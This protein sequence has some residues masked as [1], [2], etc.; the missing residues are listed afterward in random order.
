M[1]CDACRARSPQSH[2]TMS[3]RY[4]GS[5]RATPI[6]D[7]IV[8][9]NEVSIDTPVRSD[10]N[11]PQALLESRPR[12]KRMTRLPPFEGLSI[13]IPRPK[14]SNG[15]PPTR[16]GTNQDLEGK[17]SPGRFQGKLL[18]IRS[19]TPSPELPDSPKLHHIHGL[20]KA[21]DY[22]YVHKR[23]VV[24]HLAAIRA[25]A[26]SPVRDAQIEAERASSAP[27][28]SRAPDWSDT[29]FYPSGRSPVP[30]RPPRASTPE[31]HQTLGQNTHL[32]STNSPAC[33]SRNT[34]QQ[35]P[36]RLS[37]GVPFWP[38]LSPNATLQSIE[39]SGTAT[40]RPG[41]TGAA[42][43]ELERS[44][45]YTLR[46]PRSRHTS[47]PLRHEITG[48]SSSSDESKFSTG[49]MPPTP[50]EMGGSRLELRGGYGPARMRGGGGDESLGVASFMKGYG[51]KC[52]RACT[53][54]GY[55][56]LTRSGGT[57]PLRIVIPERME[58]ARDKTRRIP[59]PTRLYPRSFRVGIDDYESNNFYPDPASPKRSLSPLDP[60]HESLL[61]CNQNLPNLRGGGG[62]DPTDEARVP[63]TLYFLAGGRGRPI[64]VASWNQQRPKKRMCGLFGMALYGHKAGT[65][66]K[67][68]E[69]G[70]DGTMPEK[71]VLTGTKNVSFTLPSDSS[72]SSSSF[73]TSSNGAKG[74]EQVALQVQS[75]L[76]AVVLNAAESASGLRAPD[77]KIPVVGDA[78]TSAALG[79]PPEAILSNDSPVEDDP[80]PGL[81]AANGDAQ[82]N[83]TQAP[84]DPT[85]KPSAAHREN[86]TDNGI[87]SRSPN[88][89]NNSENAIPSSDTPH[90][91]DEAGSTSTCEPIHDNT[92]P[93]PEESQDYEPSKDTHASNGTAQT[94]NDPS[95][96]F[97]AENLAG[98]LDA[99]AITTTPSADGHHNGDDE[100]TTPAGDAILQNE[101][102]PDTIAKPTGTCN[103]AEDDTTQGNTP[104]GNT[105]TDT[106]AAS[107]GDARNN[108]AK[109]ANAPLEPKIVPGY[110]R[111][112]KKRGTTQT[113]KEGAN[114]PDPAEKN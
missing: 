48:S 93:A 81:Q 58:G 84:A 34:R 53:T 113:G 49:T 68:E 41:P 105:D 82:A 112:R 21:K 32:Q 51:E 25:G 11:V 45:V 22:P 12:P 20:P 7:A 83:S 29:V 18:P 24:E 40:V 86:T 107:A 57:S 74:D 38:A 26:P 111:G 2:L 42:E 63:A 59:L 67:N 91:G 56:R 103:T 85:P 43:T 61:A 92:T 78:P 94:E 71:S 46:S 65:P 76:S 8:E 13:S 54:C 87:N 47:S 36:L 70:T 88:K 39:A 35:P 80:T 60:P 3:T 14:S 75:D 89:S 5:R 37:T 95:S 19:K 96:D 16:R 90:A 10:R 15:R 77:D 66:Y 64:T 44:R 106:D 6:L 9:I 28:V 100:A 33:S 73:S 27:N 108:T 101:A 62:S 1:P 52:F 114:N 69:E 104:P 109:A 97:P 30:P 50:D 110:K 102:L 31:Q 4:L 72:S 55:Y 99:N 17:S 79:P 23:E 98:S